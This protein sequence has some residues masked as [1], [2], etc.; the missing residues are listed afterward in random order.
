M[1]EGVKMKPVTRPFAR[2]NFCDA[3]LGM[4]GARCAGVT[5]RRIWACEPVGRVH[6]GRAAFTRRPGARPAC[7]PTR[8]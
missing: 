1:F 2:T 6:G 7:S 4:S 5:E 3:G 8:T